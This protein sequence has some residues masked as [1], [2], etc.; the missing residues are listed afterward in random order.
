[1]DYFLHVLRTDVWFKVLI[2]IIGVCS[3]DGSIIEEQHLCEE[4]HKVKLVVLERLCSFL[5]Q[6]SRYSIEKRSTVNSI[7]APPGPEKSVQITK[8]R[9]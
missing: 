2:G 5:K 9:E 4:N 6:K 8:D 7:N 3:I 1:M